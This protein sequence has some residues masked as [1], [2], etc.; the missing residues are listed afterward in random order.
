MTGS[1]PT[2]SDMQDVQT[3]AMD[4]VPSSSSSSSLSSASS[5]PSSAPFVLAG[6]PPFSGSSLASKLHSY[7]VRLVVRAA[8][9][10]V[11]RQQE[12]WFRAPSVCGAV[13]KALCF[14]NL[15]TL[16]AGLDLTRALLQ[17]RYVLCRQCVAANA[18]CCVQSGGWQ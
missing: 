14:C 4:A 7:A 16:F 10:V 9:V 11:S 17:S 1:K 18:L 12:Q 6:A 3:A 13:T 8:R 5:F 15:M 2:N